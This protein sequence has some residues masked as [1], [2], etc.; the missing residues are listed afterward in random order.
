MTTKINAT[1][2]LKSSTLIEASSTLELWKKLTN[3]IMGDGTRSVVH[4]DDIATEGKIA[5]DP[6]LMFNAENAS[7]LSQMLRASNSTLVVGVEQNKMLVSVYAEN[8][9]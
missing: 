8:D 9:A 2:R 4:N 5:N 3:L 7:R 1:Q 6:M